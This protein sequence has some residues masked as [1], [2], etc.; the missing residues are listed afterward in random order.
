MALKSHSSKKR[1]PMADQKKERQRKQSPEKESVLIPQKYQHAA[2][3][4][5]IFISLLIFFNEIVFSG[6]VFVSGDTVAAHSWETLI[7]DA[8]AEGIFP[9]WNPYIFCGMPGYASLSIH[10]DRD[11]DITALISGRLANAFGHIMMYPDVGYIIYYYFV[12]AVGVYFFAFYKMRSKIAALIVALATVYSTF[13]IIWIMVGHVT[14]IVVIAYFPYVFW[15]VEK[16]REKFNLLLLLLLI[17]VLHLMFLPGHMQMIFYIYFA[18]G[19]YYI[20]YFIRALVKKENW[21]GVLRSGIL[22]SVASALAFGLTADQYLSTLEYAPYSIRGSDPI[23][24]AAHQEKQGSETKA[25][26]GGLD[27]DYATNWSFSPGETFTFLI[28]SLYGFGNH[29]YQ[30]VL[31]NNQLTELNTY[32]GPLSS[33][34][35][36][37][38]MGIVIVVLA[39]IGLVRKRKEP[40]VQY[41]AVM[42]LLALLISFGREFSLVYDLMFYHF[43]MFNKFRIPSMILILVQVFTPLLAGF[44]IVSLVEDRTRSLP[45]SMLIRWKYTMVTSG[46]L[47]LI[48]ITAKGLFVSIYS[49]FF[50]QADVTK[51][52]SHS[53]GN[54][55]QVLNELFNFIANA[56]ATDI[57]VAFVLLTVTFGLFYLYWQKKIS[58]NMLAVMLVAV[59]VVD[60]WRVDFKPMET[61]SREQANQYFAM[62]DY[63]KFLKQDTTL[64][65][66]L[67]FI[68][69]QPPY[70]NTLAYWRIQSAYGYQGAKV[71]AYQ[72]I[73]ENINLANPLLW[74]LMNVKYIISNQ[75]DSSRVLAPIYRGKERNVFHNRTELPRAFFVNRYEV[76]SGMEILK[77]ISTISFNPLDVAYCTED[78]Q[79]KIDPPQSGAEV[80][81]TRFGIQDLEAKVTATGNNLVFFS[82]TYYPEGW[83]AFVDNVETPIY[84]TNYLFRGVV[85]PA[86]THIVSMKFEPRGYSL[87]KQL[88]LWLNILVLGGIGILAGRKYA[89]KY[90]TKLIN[91]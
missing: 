40:F 13:V 12:F 11:F 36:P 30:G 1:S 64:Y 89:V 23:A 42:I 79:L 60:L 90:Q 66:T 88:S 49:S 69:G 37:Q 10:G 39:G 81:Y 72:D 38:Y 17:I 20:M 54:Q 46:V 43:P 73:V 25:T 71:R 27:Y 15:L 57:A 67:E 74:G 85:V 50:S 52:L 35:A 21:K 80:K 5:L 58:F 2:A 68:N 19:I 76:A 22:F 47:F 59:V 45:A 9:L 33:T 14:K 41:C 18:L 48:A 62:P 83:K 8:K 4:A 61:H 26:Q 56:V 75:L 78:P 24:Q 28:P 70:S 86:G 44:G 16:L 34:D 7:N 53:Y 65:R 3:I 55:P 63:V 82:E 51:A 87:G 77:K 84:R 6:K 91:E 32:F 29:P 31:T